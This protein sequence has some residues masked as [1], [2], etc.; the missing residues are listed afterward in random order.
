MRTPKEA[1]KKAQSLKTRLARA[2]THKEWHESIEQL[3][4]LTRPWGQAEARRFFEQMLEEGKK[5]QNPGLVAGASGYLAE[6]D[7]HAGRLVEAEQ[8]LRLVRELASDTGH[9][10]ARKNDAKL[11]GML[12]QARG[13]YQQA[14]ASYELYVRLC[15]EAGDR[16]HEMAGLEMLGI[17]SALQSSPTEALS[18][19]ERA[20]ALCEDRE[21]ALARPGITQNIGDALVQLGNWDKATEYLYRTIAACEQLG[22]RVHRLYALVNLAELLAMRNKLDQT[23]T[24]LKEAIPEA[25]DEPDHQPLYHHALAVLGWAYFLAGDLA[26]AENAYREAHEL[27]IKTDN[28]CELA[29]LCWRRAELALARGQLDAADELLSQGKALAA[30]LGL[31]NEEGQVLRVR[32]LVLAE[33]GDA[34]AARQAFEQATAVLAEVGDNYELAQSRLQHGRWLMKAGQLDTARPKL[35][36]AAETF[37]RLGAVGGLESANELLFQLT[38]RADREEALLSGLDRLRTVE[39]DPVSFLERALLFLGEALESDSGAVLLD[40]LPVAVR[41]QPDITAATEFGRQGKLA[42]SQTALSIPIRSSDQLLGSVYLETAEQAPAEP[43]P[44]AL[45]RVSGLLAEPMSRAAGLPFRFRDAEVEIPGLVYRGI[46]GRNKAMVENLRMVRRVASANVP[47]LIRGE[48]GTGKELVARAVHESGSR[49]DGPFVPVNCAA[50][51]DSLLE[52]ELFGVAKGAATGVEKRRGKFEAAHSGTIFLDEVGDMSLALQAKLLRVLQ[53]GVFVR[54]GSNKPVEVDIRVVAATN[55]DLGQLIDEEKFRADLFFRLNGVELVLPPLRERREDIPNLLSYFIAR[56]NQ[57][58]GHDAL[59]FD[60]EAQT[61][62]LEYDWPGN[63]RE[64]QHVVESAVLLAKSRLL[65]VSSLPPKLAGTKVLRAATRTEA[66]Q[67]R[68]RADADSRRTMLVDCLERAG[69]D[70]RKAAELAGY[71]MSQVYRLMKKYR[72]ARPAR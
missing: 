68:L 65:G 49:A 52:A 35:D 50:L 5:S 51:P 54:V 9:W 26:A 21:D 44:Q 53:D 29:A 62:L 14:R 40:G 36:A 37:R 32:A 43:G 33:R 71:S 69:W 56:S 38:L 31:R 42:Q 11:T 72:V 27:C 20:L 46:T 64:L 58:Y 22:R 4:A 16:L 19:Y 60:D 17:L 67:A 3:V 70:V 30:Q 23:A 63:I 10:V 13:E 6:T 66:R 61:V 28:R 2:K 48:S 47:V 25:R 1:L 55:Q 18:Y 8:L 24:M 39:T 45:E 57:E 7:I 41:G 15:Q 12:H 59:G 34:E